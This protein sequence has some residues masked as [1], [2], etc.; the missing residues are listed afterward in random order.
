MYNQ[1]WITMTITVPKTFEVRIS[2]RKM[3]LVFAVVN[4]GPISDNAADLRY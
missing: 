1:C 4:V 2:A 3:E